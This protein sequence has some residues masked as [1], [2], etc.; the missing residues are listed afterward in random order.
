MVPALTAVLTLVAAVAENGVIGRDGGLPWRLPEDLKRF[1]R[2]TL[3]NTVLMGRKTFESLG[4]PLD[5]RS[6]WV[7]TRQP[8]FAPAGVRVFHDLETV[9][10]QPPQGQLMVIGGA[11]LYRLTLPLAQRL[12]LTRVHAAVEGDTRFP[13]FD[14]AQWREMARED[15]PADPRHAWPYSFV[16]LV[17]A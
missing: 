9:L 1:R 7:L 13:Q 10:A 8:G 16:T 12:E 14:P 5:G 3:G 15:H 17:R 11:E 4:K 2:L 6:N